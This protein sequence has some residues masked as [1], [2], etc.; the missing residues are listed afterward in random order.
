M[1]T[2]EQTSEELLLEEEVLTQNEIVLH[3]DD[4]NTF[5]HVIETLIY[6]CEHTPEQ[7]E[8]CAMLVHYKGKC[9]VKTG[10]LDDLKPRCSMLLEAGLSAELV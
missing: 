7:A 4:V 10:L 3:N 1:S 2:R 9:T 5:D 8:Q 6:A